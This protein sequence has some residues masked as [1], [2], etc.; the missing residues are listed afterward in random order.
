MWR[1]QWVIS[2]GDNL[3]CCSLPQ[4]EALCTCRFGFP[5]ATK[6]CC[7]H[8]DVKVMPDA[9]FTKRMC[10][11]C[12]SLLKGKDVVATSL[13]TLRWMCD[14]PWTGCLWW[15]KPIYV[16]RTNNNRV[17]CCLLSQCEA[18]AARAFLSQHHYPCHLTNSTK[19]VR[20]MAK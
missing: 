20:L 13:L 5:S 15:I 6:W 7:D 2:S 16:A 1:K 9:P 10:D 14:S 18:F 12:G 3:C 11:R 17:I 4:C 19:R 8:D